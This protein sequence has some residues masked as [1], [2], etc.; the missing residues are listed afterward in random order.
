MTNISSQR[1][2]GGEAGSWEGAG[3]SDLGLCRRRSSLAI[4]HTQW[5]LFTYQTQLL[6]VSA[7]LSLFPLLLLAPLNTAEFEKKKEREASAAETPLDSNFAVGLGA[8]ESL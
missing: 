3:K 7:F 1:G 2:G 8:G 5:K 4:S 6:N